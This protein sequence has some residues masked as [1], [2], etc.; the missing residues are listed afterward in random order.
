MFEIS[1]YEV[2]HRE[3]YNNADVAVNQYSNGGYGGWGA[4]VRASGQQYVVGDRG[5]LCEFSGLFGGTSG[6][7]SPSFASNNGK[8]GYGFDTAPPD[9]KGITIENCT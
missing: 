4:S 8:S 6:E 9:F 7:C 5:N 3:Q 2:C 1:F